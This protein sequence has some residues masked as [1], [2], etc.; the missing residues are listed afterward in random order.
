M[1]SLF[2][3]FALLASLLPVAAFFGLKQTP[4]ARP[5]AEPLWPRGAPG[6]LGSAPEDIPTIQI[7]L[8]AAG[9]GNGAAM[10]ICPGGGYGGLADYEG[11]PIAQWFSSLGGTAAV[12]KYR[13]GSNHYRHPA[14]LNDASR[15]IRILRS[16]AGELKLDKDHIAIL[17][18]SAG[19]HLA[20][21]AATHFDDG[22][23]NAADPIDRVSS[24]PD[25]AILCYPVISMESPYTHMG[26]RMNLLGDQPS[27]ELIK[28]LSNE[29]QVTPKTP[30]TFLWHTAD[31][32]AVPMEN[33]LL[34]AM[35]CHK[36]HVPVELHVYSHGRHGMGMGVGDPVV[37]AW[38]AACAAWMKAI[39]FIK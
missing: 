18:F 6:A 9:K 37:G 25:A 29:Q 5:A 20:S 11:H 16:R 30:P 24:R 10:V 12:L 36:N 33:S 4:N 32:E 21:T 22:D 31:D 34:F 8:P 23:P 2:S 1:Q 17:G 19:G 27:P 14:M 7:Y 3:Q 13:L 39:G 38:P 15:A 28:L 35:A 26:S